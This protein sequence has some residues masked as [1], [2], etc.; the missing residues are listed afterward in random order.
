[1][2]PHRA[3]FFSPPPLKFA[4]GHGHVC[5]CA[6]ACVCARVR[7]CACARVWVG[8]CGCDIGVISAGTSNDT[9]FEKLK[10]RLQFVMYC[11]D[12]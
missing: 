4:A 8:V 10:K 3:E 5:S 11:I 1:V 7:A 2:V 6:F 9:E 12:Y